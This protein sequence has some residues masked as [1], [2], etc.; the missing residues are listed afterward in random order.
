MA[1][2]WFFRV[3]LPPGGAPFLLGQDARFNNPLG[4]NIYRL[5]WDNGTLVS[6]EK[7]QLPGGLNIYGFTPAEIGGAARARDAATARIIAAMLPG[8][9]ASSQNS[10]DGPL[11]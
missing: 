9:G 5:T 8:A 7:H 1:G 4:G 11:E 6:G 10:A 2:P 3:I